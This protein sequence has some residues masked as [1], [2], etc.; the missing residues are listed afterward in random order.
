[1]GRRGN[2]QLLYVYVR[3]ITE[4]GLTTG[5]ATITYGE[6]LPLASFDTRSI[7]V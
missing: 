6:L 3:R 7:T 4:E 2:A 1:M 5:T